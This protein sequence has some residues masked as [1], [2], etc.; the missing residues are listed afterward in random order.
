M[1]NVIS[2]TQARIHFG[3][4]LQQVQ[5]GAVVVVEHAGK[6]AAVVLSVAAYARLK[7]EQPV[8]RQTLAQILQLN[9]QRQAKPGGTPPL[10][11]PAAILREVR[12]ARDAQLD[13]L[14]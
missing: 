8:W 14:P 3:K 12:E 2:A 10:T 13:S 6:P 9:A 4:L 1:E 7:G 11:P 5:A